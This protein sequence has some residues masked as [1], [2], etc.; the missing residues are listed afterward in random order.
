MQPRRLT[1]R[2]QCSE[3]RGGLFP[4]YF[5]QVYQLGG[6]A[7]VDIGLFIRVQSFKFID[8]ILDR[9]GLVRGFT[10]FAAKFWRC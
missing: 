8:G 3:S 2:A 7:V 4:H 1:Y 5:D 9:L 10:G 6:G